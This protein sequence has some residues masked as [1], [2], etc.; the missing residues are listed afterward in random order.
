MIDNSKSHIELL[1]FFIVFAIITVNK[2]FLFV[3]EKDVFR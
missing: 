3:R 1:Q 2:R